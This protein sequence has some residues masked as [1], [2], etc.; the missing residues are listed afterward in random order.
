MKKIKVLHVTF[1]MAIG[2]TEQVIRQ[3]VENTDTER[4]EPSIL[5]IDGKIGE[6]GELLIQ[7]G[8]K[9]KHLKRTPGFDTSLIKNIRLL[10]SEDKIDILHC[11]QYTPY[12]YGVLASIITR[13]K[14]VFTEHGRFY[15][16]VRKW[17]RAIANPLLSTITHSVTAISKATAKALVD[18]ENIPQRKIQVIYNGIKDVA[19]IE[20]DNSAVYGEFGIPLNHKVI[21][22]ISRL[23]PIKNQEMMLKAFSSCLEREPETTFLFVGDGPCRKDLEEL[24]QNLGI[25]EKVV[26]AGF[27]VNPQRYLQAM[28]VFLLGSLSEGTSM[29]LLEAMAFSKASVVTDVGGNPELITNNIEGLITKNDDQDAFSNAVIRILAD[30]AL[31]SKLGKSARTRYENT[32][33]VSNMINAYQK[34]YLKLA[35]SN[36]SQTQT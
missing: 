19:K 30:P 12:V 28:D 15:P 21:G 34:L 6:L 13:T 9:I 23:D 17:K 8:V 35:T 4:F 1:D 22:T 24:A 20:H 26:F 10:I 5:C 3:I 29:T 14:V 33:T 7:K 36:H 25:A 32:F 2:G 18:F 27:K 31:Q 16:D 11:H